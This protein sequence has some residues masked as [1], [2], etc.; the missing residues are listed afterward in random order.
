MPN[1]KSAKKALRQNRKRY[2]VNRSAKTKMKLMVKTVTAQTAAATFSVIDKAAKN[3]LIHKNKA[4][5]LKS[6]ISKKLELDKKGL[7]K[8][9]A[10][11]QKATAAKSKKSSK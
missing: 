9:P 11:I 1:L 10:A 7:T 2:I 5:R 4:A 3:N 6:Q 8:R